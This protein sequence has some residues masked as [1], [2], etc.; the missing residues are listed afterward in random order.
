M[1][2][3]TDKRNLKNFE[4]LTSNHQRVFKHRIKEKCNSA[5]KDIGVVANY[6]EKLKF[7]VDKILDINQLVNL[8][9]LYEKLSLLQ[10]V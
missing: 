5:L 6:H 3:P 2:T 8:M 7:K 9:D 4:K 10:N 1:L